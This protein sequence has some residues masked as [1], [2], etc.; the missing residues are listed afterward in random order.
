M[1]DEARGGGRSS[2][3]FQEVREKRGLAYS[4][5]SFRAAFA[6]AGALAVYAGTSP[7]HLHEVLDLI[8]RELDD[9]AANGVT[10]RELHVAKGHLRGTM[11]LG[12]EDSGS[13]MSRIGRSQLV[14]DE[15][16][17]VDEINARIDAVTIDDV[18]R[19]SE[20]VLRGPRVLAVVG[21]FDESEFE[22]VAS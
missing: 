21:P 13:R 19:V 11:L 18:R 12:L 1:L 20:A 10:P 8:T 3:L 16:P 5:Y 15:A 22:P 14:H 2:R 7:D 17:T 4:V 6:D 9:L